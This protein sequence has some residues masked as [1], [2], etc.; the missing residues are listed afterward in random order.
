MPNL[1][2]IQQFKVLTGNSEAQYGN[3]SG[4]QVIVETKSGSNQL[5]GSAF[6]FVRNTALD[7]RN[8]FSATRATYD[9]NQFGGTLGGPI[10]KDKL[11][12][13]IDYQGTRLTQGVDS[14]LISVPSQQDRNGDLSDLA[15]QL[16]GQ[17]NGAGLASSLSQKLGYTVTPGES[18][19]TPNCVN[20]AQCVFP[21]A[22]IPQSA[23][24]VPAGNLLG[25]IPSPNRGAN[26]FSTS[27]ENE[28]LRDDK[29]GAR[30]D[31]VTRWGNL[32]AYY[33]AD[34]YFLNNPY[35]TSQGGA[36]VPGFNALTSGRAQLMSFGWTKTIG[37][38]AVNEF[39]FSYA[40]D[41]N[42]VGKP[43]G[44]VGP[45]LASQ[46][47]VDAS[48]KPSIY[49]L[50][51]EIEGIE[52]VVFNDFTMGVDTTGL[53]EVNNTYQW[54]DDYS[55]TFGKH[56]LRVGGGYHIDQI[57]ITP[58]AI[59]NGSFAFTGSATGS[60]FADFLLGLSQHL[61]AGRFQQVLSAQQVRR[62]LWSGQL[63]SEFE[64]YA[65]LWRALGAA[66]GMARKVQP[67]ANAFARSTVGGLS[68][69]AAR[70]GIPGRSRHSRHL[71]SHQTHQLRA[72]HWT[73]LLPQL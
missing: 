68:R 14:G 45:S 50:A 16:T 56:T 37:T 65:E 61:L 71:G 73:G 46:G 59:Y 9:Q 48:G 3:F 29:G 24:S 51:P 53:T 26:L 2:S 33:F 60:D 55:R 25:Y 19:Y 36:N 18:Y 43:Q 49:A 52:N 30:F 38:N 69:R 12:F 63:A 5:H 7:A 1:D 35:P 64:P 11:F 31:A 13:F 58:D 22:V 72:S 57:N 34:D 54:T 28:T 27:A 42:I 62:S 6:D 10:K 15:S 20:P 47:F 41:A 17:V 32:S 39:H 8:Y 23:W 70:S 40:R 67:A 21:N 66:A 44:G 4:G